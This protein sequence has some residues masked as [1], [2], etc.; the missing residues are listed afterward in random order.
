MK[1]HKP[2]VT[3]AKVALLLLGLRND[4]FMSTQLPVELLD[5][6]ERLLSVTDTYAQPVLT[7]ARQGYHQRLVSK[8]L[9]IYPRPVMNP[10]YIVAYRKIFCEQQVRAAIADGA[11]QVII[12]GGGYDTLAWRL[13]PE[14]PAVQFIELDHP[15]TGRVKARGI[16]IMGQPQNLRLIQADL[17][18]VS[19]AQ[20]LGECV[21]VNLPTVWLAEGLFMYLSAMQILRLLQATASLCAPGSRMAFD[22][23]YQ[24]KNGQP[25]LGKTTP[26]ILHWLSWIGEPIRW[27]IN[28]S[29]LA[30]FVKGSG[31]NY[32]PELIP[33]RKSTGLEHFAVLCK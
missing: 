32:C 22:H 11:L 28:P 9:S 26:L 33:D 25:A 1:T 5:A 6:V 3:A 18:Q 14:F 30:G 27:S 23:F 2:S 13:A 12:L 15:A 7:L 16:Q 19:L 24:Q 17:G 20:A 10:Y 21:N 4:P 8:V 31:W 29:R